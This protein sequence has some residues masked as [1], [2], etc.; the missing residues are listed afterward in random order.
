MVK[1]GSALVKEFSEE[2]G[3]VAFLRFRYLLGGTCGKDLSAATAAVGTEVDE[4]V[5]TLDDVEVVLDDDDG[6]A[7]IDQA[8]QHAEKDADVLEV[9][10]RGGLVEDVE[11]AAGVAL[12]ELGGEFHTL[13]L[14]AGEGGGGLAELDVAE[15]YVLQRLDLLEYGGLVLEELHGTVDGHVEHVGDALALEAHLE[16]LA[17]V[18]LAVTL[19]AGH[20]H[21]GQEIHL[22][23]LVAVAA[24]CLATTALHVEREA[25]GL[26]AADAGLGQ[27][28]E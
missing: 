4:V 15:T 9:Q 14:A 22:D 8:L 11:R 23:G 13:A 3:G 28:D 6:V 1:L 19:L 2:L 17:V 20:H 12:G 25:T 16:R 7:L 5:G 21:V 26:V 10:A 27:R 24:A 18:A